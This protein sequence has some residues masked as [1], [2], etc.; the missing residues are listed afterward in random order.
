MITIKLLD[1]YTDL[2]KVELR[3][4]NWDVQIR[5]EPYQVWRVEGYYHTI[6]G[7]WGNN[8]YWGCPRGEEPT[9]DN[10]VEFNGEACLWGVEYRE[11]HYYRCKWGETSI[12]K[13]RGAMV[14]RNGEDF[15][16]VAG[17]MVYSLPKAMSIIT[18]LNEDRP[19]INF[20]AYDFKDELL[21][22]KV[23]Y[24]EEPAIITRYIGQGQCC[25]ILEPDGFEK[26]KTPIGWSNYEWSDYAESCKTDI[27][28]NDDIGWFRK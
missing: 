1:K 12:E 21:G 6:G 13:G 26:F 15:Y 8:C 5:D 20:N 3:K 18:D 16:R 17:E 27:I 19:P 25:V 24:K 14:T 9:V 11:H 2:S 7:R 28:H 4:F 23:W 10:L 22:R